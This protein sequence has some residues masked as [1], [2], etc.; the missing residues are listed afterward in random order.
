MFSF[1]DQVV[2][3]TGGT[4]GIGKTISVGFLKADAKVIA[5]YTSNDQK[6]EEFKIENSAYD[7]KLD[8]QKLD[9]TDYNDVEK[10]YN[11]I[12]EKYGSVDVLVNNAGV[13][14]DS[15][16]GMMPNETW[17]FV[18]NVN[19]NGTFCMSRFA[20]RNMIRKRYGRIINITSPSSY[21]GFKG[22]ANYAASKAGQ[23]GMSRVLSKEV[24]GYGITVNCVSPGFIS[25]ELLNDL[26]ESQINEYKKM[27]PLGRFADP[28]EIAFGVLFLASKE[29]SY[30][31]GTTL[32]ISGGI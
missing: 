13:R 21:L 19:L 1:K 2:I 14:K 30:I 4:R 23:I 3:V 8:L 5:V 31:T 27:I 7:E 11:Y 28:E 15:L 26:D 12:E 32:T 29:A 25:T 6:A 24:A 16:L 17:Q 10:F 9:I 22:Q 20:V 18:I